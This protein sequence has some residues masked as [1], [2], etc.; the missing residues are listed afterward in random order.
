MTHICFVQQN[1]C[2]NREVDFRDSNDW[3][4]CTRCS[5]LIKHTNLSCKVVIIKT[6]G[7]HWKSVKCWQTCG[8]SEILEELLVEDEGHTADLFYFGFSCGVAIDEVCCDSN[9]KFTAEFFSAKP[10]RKEKAAT[11]KTRHTFRE[12]SVC[13]RQVHSQNKK[14]AGMWLITNS[15]TEERTIASSEE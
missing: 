4:P 13:H 14:R 5:F 6:N 9:C 15:S 2:K 10:Y 11:L 8:I 1:S 7:F 3:L 12:G